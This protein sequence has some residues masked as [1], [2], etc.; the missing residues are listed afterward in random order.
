MCLFVW[1][2]SEYLS[3][4]RHNPG[5]PR[6]ICFRSRH[7]HIFPFGFPFSRKITSSLPFFRLFNLKKKN[8]K[9]RIQAQQVQRNMSMKQSSRGAQRSFPFP[10]HLDIRTIFLGCRVSI[11]FGPGKRPFMSASSV[12]QVH[13][14]LPGHDCQ[15]PWRLHAVEHPRAQSQSPARCTVRSTVV[16][17]S[18][19]RRQQS[20]YLQTRVDSSTPSTRSVS[21][22]I[23]QL[24]H[25]PL[26]SLA[27]RLRCSSLQSLS[28]HTPPP[29]TSYGHTR[30]SVL[31]LVKCASERCST[32]SFKALRSGR[33]IGEEE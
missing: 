10:C 15:R 29:G 4:L 12:Y 17:A 33:R 7:S 14:A 5:N 25:I 28:R 31:R 27:I 6:H 13:Q 20:P 16:E 9:I 1:L 32:A 18:R 3:T 23:T 11:M 8:S 30:R 26:G 21:S 22:L 19:A 24:Y 2:P